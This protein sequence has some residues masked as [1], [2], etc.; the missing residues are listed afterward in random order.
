MSEIYDRMTMAVVKQ[1]T[2]LTAPTLTTLWPALCPVYS[3]WWKTL[4]SGLCLQE[5]C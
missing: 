3:D 1:C 2:V 5:L 4:L